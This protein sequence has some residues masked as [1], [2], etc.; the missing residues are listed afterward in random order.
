MQG[1]P[2]T[3]EQTIWEGSS[4]QWLNFKS[5]FLSGLVG[6]LILAALGWAWG[7]LPPQAA[8]YRTPI[9]LGLAGLLLVPAFIALRGYL[10][11][12]CRRYTLTT[13]RL[14]IARGILSKRTD[15]TELYRIDDILLVQPFL[16]RL[17]S[18]GNVVLT[19]SDRTTPEILIEA[20][21][22]PT[23]LRDEVRRY[24]EICRDRKKT[25]VLDFE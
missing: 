22:N 2:A 19:T 20:V 21:R 9:L 18:R 8:S 14:R 15:D 12:R 16:L 25:R 6:L 7:S 5:F 10:E 4:S 13:E 24:V 3:Q 17:V 1:M 23:W 11:I